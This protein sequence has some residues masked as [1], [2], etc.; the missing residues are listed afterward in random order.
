MTATVDFDF[1]GATVTVT[2]TKPRAEDYRTD[3]RRT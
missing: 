1:T 3:V 2:G